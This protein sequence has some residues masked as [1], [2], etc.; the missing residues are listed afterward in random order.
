[1]YKIKSDRELFN[2]FKELNTQ[3]QQVQS[4]FSLKEQ[5]LSSEELEQY[6]DLANSLEDAVIRLLLDA[7]E[8]IEEIETDVEDVAV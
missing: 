6:R 4:Y 1:M 2:R 8:R 5:V 7:D 3:V